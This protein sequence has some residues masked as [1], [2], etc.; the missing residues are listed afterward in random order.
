M[1]SRFPYWK[2]PTCSAADMPSATYR[3]SL[4]QALDPNSIQ[5][6][7]RTLCDRLAFTAQYAELILYYDQQNQL[8]G[9]WQP[10]LL[11]DPI[12]LLAVISKTDYTHYYREFTAIR[13]RLF[14][15]PELVVPLATNIGDRAQQFNRLFELLSAMFVEINRWIASMKLDNRRYP[16]R[17]FVEQKLQALINSL[18]QQFLQLQ[19]RSAL[20]SK[21]QVKASDPQC[22]QNFDQIWQRN[23]QQRDLLSENSDWQQLFAVLQ[24]LYHQVFS[25]FLQVIDS[26]EQGFKQLLNT[27][28]DYPDTALLIAFA[29]LMA[30]QQ[31]SINQYGEQHLN[32]YYHTLLHQYPQ[33]AEADQV[34]V[35]LRL[36]EKAIPLTLKARTAFLAGLYPDK[37]EIIFTAERSTEIN[38]AVIATAKT[39][40]YQPP[41]CSDAGLYQARIAADQIQRDQQK[42]II[43]W[44]AFG[45]SSGTEI[46]QG[47]ALASPLLYLQGGER[48]ITLT[49]C[50]QGS[51]QSNL[52][53]DSQFFLST[54]KGWHPVMAQ[55]TSDNALQTKTI[56]TLKIT[57]ALADPPIST[58]AAPLDGIDSPWPLCKV[59]LAA[60]TDL[61]QP[62][63]LTAVNIEVDV[64]QLTSAVIGN[65]S[66][67]L[68]LG[69]PV[70][71]FGPV[72]ELG[73]FFYLGSNEC[74]AKPLINL[75]LTL[76]WDHL[77][78]DFSS[79]YAAYNIF[80]D[81][82]PPCFDN[83][84][85]QSTW[86]QLD[87]KQW[88]SIHPQIKL[89][90]VLTFK[91]EQKIPVTLIYDADNK[92]PTK[93]TFEAAQAFQA[94][95]TLSG[96]YPIESSQEGK[97]E[98]FFGEL[99]DKISH[100]IELFSFSKPNNT[101]NGHS[102]FSDSTA[103]SD[104]PI[105]LDQNQKIDAVLTFNPAEKTDA[106]LTF[107]PTQQLDTKK[108]YQA[109]LTFA[110]LQKFYAALTVESLSELDADLMLK[111]AQNID[112]ILTI[113]PA[114]TTKATLTFP[115]SQN[116]E[117]NLA[118]TVTQQSLFQQVDVSSDQNLQQSH[119][120]FDVNG[121]PPV[122]TLICEPIPALNEA[123]AG[124]LRCTLMEPKYAFGSSLYAQVLSDVTWQNAKK[125]INA[126]KLGIN[127]NVALKDL[128]NPPYSPKLS[129][130]SLHYQAA[131]EHHFNDSGTSFSQ[132]Q[133]YPLTFYHYGSFQNYLVYETEQP[134]NTA[135]GF[136]Q[137][138]PQSP[139]VPEKPSAAL[140]LFTGV[141]APGALY[142]ALQG[143][144]P[145]CTLSL[146]F[147]ISQGAGAA[148]D[149]PI[150]YYC[151]SEQGWQPLTCLLDE[152]R[153]LNC[154]GIV[155][156]EIPQ[157]TATPYPVCPLMPG[158][159]FWLLI[160]AKQAARQVRCVYLNSQVLRLQRLNLKPLARGE[161]P[162][163]PAST[164]TALQDNN[165]AVA[166]IIQPF[167]S[168]NGQAAEDQSEYR[169]RVSQRLR[170]KDRAGS[171]FDF[172]TLALAAD[173][174][175]YY[176]KTFPPDD[177]TIGN[178]TI[179]VGVVPVIAD[180]QQADAL[181]PWISIC[182]QRAIQQYLAD[183]ASAMASIT[184]CNFQHQ[185]IT[186][187][188]CLTIKVTSQANSLIQQLDQAL[189]LYLSP[190]I[191]SDQP[192]RS[193]GQ[194]VSRAGLTALLSRPDEVLGIKDLL[195]FRT[196]LNSDTEEEVS[197]EVVMPHPPD[198]L[199]VSAQQ[200][201]IQVVCTV[202]PIRA[203]AG[204]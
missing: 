189:K 42:N 176:A 49:M 16:L 131:T 59:I 174:A 150:K 173:P 152:T 196:P 88:R 63:Q 101:L 187:Q 188:V 6:D 24:D 163:I 141:A 154:S 62:P 78:S 185:V 75:S 134:R 14:Q 151:W 60:S 1:S 171:S 27:Q 10:F 76:S 54:S 68:P 129:R 102:P 93:L 108:S 11:K 40:Y 71:F 147:E 79:Y 172:D 87:N 65:T 66:S 100:F 51:V 157:F 23:G 67:P 28:S 3:A 133:D 136:K 123:S 85:F 91:T 193:I 159:D 33:G 168:F 26:A 99:I 127:D 98:S 77:P 29:K 35:C 128:P 81:T 7:E 195:I 56:I 200:H 162:V 110:P 119:F 55:S 125:I 105:T 165:P 170:N 183:R 191:P 194:G 142:I 74:F 130:F 80:L 140:P 72:P 12:I 179:R 204:G 90:A 36:A 58:S 2:A 82:D 52:F 111:P 169:W 95:M 184:V 32:F 116:L 135:L 161:V 117:M 146:L 158:K 4:L 22:Y 89:D 202:M 138:M 124:Y 181:R 30:H 126:T 153:Q 182:R 186:V 149:D 148:D 114:D 199:L 17:N 45:S 160:T 166:T 5:V 15:A 192:Q 177:I 31:Q 203:A 104:A 156:L 20:Q 47:F 41:R 64:K 44:P 143:I 97:A 57:L 175:L 43:S 8:S 164:I 86:Q 201:K 21:Q 69:E 112:V 50:F 144:K 70:F 73:D 137:L 9:D 84:C 103:K 155:T 94:I 37:T 190:W 167:P 92:F 46:F 107:N 18:F 121:H 19:H 122:P 48:T 39:L 115:A 139:S 197:D 83:T 109:T 34:Y 38:H 113:N 180:M 132:T 178:G 106:T 53:A 61:M 13:K 96:G 25:F 118:V 120:A 145:P 198:A